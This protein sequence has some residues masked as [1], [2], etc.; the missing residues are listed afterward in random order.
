[1]NFLGFARSFFIRKNPFVAMGAEFSAIIKDFLTIKKKMRMAHYRVVYHSNQLHKMER[2]IAE[3]N[4]H[5]FLRGKKINEV[6]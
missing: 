4:E 3:N 6:R 2:L 5:S 1:M